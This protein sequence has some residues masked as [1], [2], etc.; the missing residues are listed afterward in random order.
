MGTAPAGR[1]F[2]AASLREGRVGC[3]ESSL[4]CLLSGSEKCFDGETGSGQKETRLQAKLQALGPP[5]SPGCL[6]SILWV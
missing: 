5:F 2:W 3:G 4:S 1:L 6:E